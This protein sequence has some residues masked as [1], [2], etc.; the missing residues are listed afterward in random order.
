MY[1]VL[2]ESAGS[3]RRVNKMC[4]VL[5]CYAAVIICRRFGTTCG[6]DVKGSSI[7]KRIHGL[8]DA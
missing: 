7:P 1:T 3:D 6:P 8:L 5:G 2:P 4:A